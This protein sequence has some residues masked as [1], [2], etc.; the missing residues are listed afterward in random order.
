MMAVHRS[1]EVALVEGALVEPQ[2]VYAVIH[3]Y[4]PPSDRAEQARQK[5]LACEALGQLLAA[6]GLSLMVDIKYV[7]SSDGRRHNITRITRVNALDFVHR[8]GAEG[9]V[10]RSLRWDED[11]RG[12]RRDDY[13]KAWATACKRVRPTSRT[14]RA[15]P[16][17][18][19]AHA[20]LDRPS[21]RI[22]CN[23]SAGC[24]TSRYRPPEASAAESVPAGRGWSGAER[25]AASALAGL[26]PLGVAVDSFIVIGEIRFFRQRR[27][28]RE[29][30]VG[31]IAEN[32]EDGSFL[33]LVDAGGV[34]FVEETEFPCF[35]FRRTERVHE[36]DALEWFVFARRLVEFVFDVHTRNVVGQQHDF[37]GVQFVGVIV[38]V[39]FALDFLKG[40]TLNVQIVPYKS[41]PEIVRAALAVVPPERLVAAPDCGMKFLPRSVAFAKLSA[42]VEGAAQVRAQL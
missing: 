4:L 9:R 41:S 26:P 28:A 38:F 42:L 25:A 8:A 21:K 5:R 16:S 37:V 23:S 13:R 6:P 10:I 40:D 18:T 3:F 33:L 31:R 22:L 14:L 39:Q 7:E 20:S 11:D 2:G 30:V 15:L 32:D 1:H 34:F 12:H 36:A 29:T 19:N 27:H 17:T 35:T 24:K